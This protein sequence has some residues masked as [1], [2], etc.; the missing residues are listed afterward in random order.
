MALGK[1]LILRAPSP[2]QSLSYPHGSAPPHKTFLS[3]LKHGGLEREW[4]R[5]RTELSQAELPSLWPVLS[6]VCLLLGR[7]N[8]RVQEGKHSASALVRTLSW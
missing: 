6:P 4:P 3:W 7:A 1:E 8:N 2:P 5:Q